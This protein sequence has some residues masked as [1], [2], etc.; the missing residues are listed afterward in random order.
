MIRVASVTGNIEQQRIP[1]RSLGQVISESFAVYGKNFWR[2]VGLIALVHV[3]AKLL[4]L[5]P[6][7]GVIMFAVIGLISTIVLVISY[8]A[9]IYYVGSQYVTNNV[10]VKT[11]YDRVWW[12]VLSLS[13]VAVVIAAIT[14]PWYYVSVITAGAAVGDE[15]VPSMA[16][17]LG[18]IPLAILVIIAIYAVFT[19]QAV[20]MEGLKPIAAFKRSFTLVKGSWLRIF[21][22][23]AVIMSIG[24]G[25]GFVIQIPFAEASHAVGLS[26]TSLAARGF[27]VA[28][29]LATS[30]IVL[31]V[32]FS[33]ITL[34]YYD[35]RVRKERYDLLQLSRELG[36]PN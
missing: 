29:G 27:T 17:L 13:I 6:S 8:G 5:I 20:I 3:P 19:P 14:L 33:G 35:V 18:I 1:E 26:N 7:N 11:C 32:I 23:V 24:A 12:R 4:A 30:F 10:S 2:F 25:L 21:G 15:S 34:L 9:A 22:V 31:P 36:H 16:G 28:A